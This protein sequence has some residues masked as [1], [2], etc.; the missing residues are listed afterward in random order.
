MRKLLFTTLAAI[1]LPTM[2]FALPVIA[3]PAPSFTVKDID[4]KTVKSD[5]LKG[6]IIVLEWNNPTC[7]FVHKHYDSNNMQDMQ[8]EATKSGVVWIT[9]NSGSEG[10]VGTLDAK[11]AH[12]Y[13]TES[14]LSSTHYI[15]D[16]NGTLGR[17]YGAKTTPHMFVIDKEGKMAYMGAIDSDSDVNADSIKKADNYVR[18]AITALA[19]GKPIKTTSTQSYGCG[20]KYAE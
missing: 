2:A 15:L 16:S 12:E 7:P 10:K 18:D 3:E 6:K 9:V 20:V 11:T 1:L 14:K 4:G 19:A 17:L 8:A 13:I 5:D